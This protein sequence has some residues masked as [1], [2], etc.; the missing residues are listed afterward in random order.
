MMED[1]ILD[2]IR[3]KPENAKNP[4]ILLTKFYDIMVYSHKAMMQFPRAEKYQLVASIKESEKACM[5]EII[6]LEKKHA[7]KTSL[8]RIDTELEYLRHL[9]RMAC[10][11]GYISLKKRHTWISQLDEAGRILGGLIKH[12]V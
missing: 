11:L 6:D 5:H 9:V 1:T 4:L 7:K 3:H 2:D 10:D 8:Q 12:F